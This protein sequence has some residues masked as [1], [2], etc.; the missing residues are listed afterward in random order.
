M[1]RFGDHATVIGAS[2]AGLL[3]ARVLAE[4]FDRVTVIDRDRLPEL[5][6]GRGAVPQGRHAHALLPAGQDVLE[7]LLPGF[8]AE[9]VAAGA[10]SYEFGA[11]FRFDA[12]GH[13]IARVRTGRTALVASRPLI[14]GL[15]RRRVGALE[16]VEI[17]DRCDVVG[18]VPSG[19]GP[20]VTGVRLLARAPG[21]AEETLP[22]DLVVAASGR[23]GRIPA[24]LESLGYR[25]PR[26]ERVGVD[27]LYRSVRVRVPAGALGH[28]RMILV[29]P[30]PGH[31][32]GMA[33]FEQERDHWLMTLYGYGAANH[34]PADR[35]GFLEFAATIADRDVIAVLR[36]AE[37]LG[38]P[39]AHRF[40]ASV[41]R[42]YEK[43]R[44]FP[45]GFLVVGD[46][47]ASFNPIYG[48]GMTVAGL[49]ALALRRCLERGQ[50]NLARRFF[51]AASRPLGHAWDV[52][53][54]ADLALPEVAPRLPAPAR[55]RNAYI[56]RVQ[57]TAGHDEVMA[58]AFLDVTGML[59]PPTHLM[60]PRHVVRTI[61]GSRRRISAAEPITLPTARARV[62]ETS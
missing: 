49:Q 46:A 26:E 38:D 40:P 28:D 50:R 37:W 58:R 27:I 52:S 20:R 48:Q 55:A 47:I 11:D 60:R 62:E 43:L 23:G 17:R 32:R 56:D 7:E 34:P 44:R 31:T 35:D 39:A 53:V 12:G 2:V 22:S 54:G 24:W 5:G 16:N 51:R 6:E 61:A 41:R 4:A 13:R 42:R 21:S 3:A 29:G 36:R 57:A 1:R 45:P 14:E 18:L 10:P 8:I 9:A 30:T 33:L 19:A 15:V 59:R 25:R